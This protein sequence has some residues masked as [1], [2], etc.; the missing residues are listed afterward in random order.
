MKCG[1]AAF[2]LLF[3]EDAALGDGG[4]TMCH[5]VVSLTNFDKAEYEKGILKTIGESSEAFFWKF[6][7]DWK[8]TVSFSE[9]ERREYLDWV[10]GLL[11]RRVESIMEG[12]QFKKL[13]DEMRQ[14]W[15]D[16]DANEYSKEARQW[17][18]DSGLIK[19]GTSGEFN[20]MWE[21]LMTREQ[22]V[23]LLYRF[24]Q[25]MGAVPTSDSSK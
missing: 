21:D 12:K 20:G 5:M 16:N 25:M 8:K 1:I 19:G 9:E 22:V 4:K 17:A 14:Q 15:R 2:L 6:W 3:M 23:T 24:A 13:F 11:V 10:S 18:A 7:S